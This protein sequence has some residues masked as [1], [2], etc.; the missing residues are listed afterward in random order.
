MALFSSVKTIRAEALLSL[1]TY[2]KH[3]SQCMLYVISYHDAWI[4][5]MSCQGKAVFETQ[6]GQPL[7]APDIEKTC[8]HPLAHDIFDK[9]ADSKPPNLLMLARCKRNGRI[10]GL[11]GRSKTKVPESVDDRK[12]P[13]KY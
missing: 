4:P 5:N 3:L 8:H 7:Y 9:K 13:S 10:V 11:S 1:H 6:Q 12:L 2:T